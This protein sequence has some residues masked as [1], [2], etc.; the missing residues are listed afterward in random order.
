MPKPKRLPKK[1]Q[2]RNP[3]PGK[4]P[5]APPQM[6]IPIEAIPH[7][8]NKKLLDWHKAQFE[9]LSEIHKVLEEIRDA[10]KEE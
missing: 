7:M 6:S 8:F 1:L 9:A 10:L 5:A 2:T 4:T 3:K